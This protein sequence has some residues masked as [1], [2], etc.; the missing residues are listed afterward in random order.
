MRLNAQAHALRAE[1]R[2]LSDNLTEVQRDVGMSRAAQL[3]EAN[4]RLVLAALASQMAAEVATRNLVKVVS[5]NQRD[6]LTNTPNRTLMQDR[7]E[8]AMALAQRR[9]TR[10]AV[11]FVDLDNFKRINDTL[12]HAAGDA[13]LQTLARRL[14]SCV[15]ESDTVSRH[16]GDEFLVLLSEVSQASDAALIAKKLL[17]DIV[18]P[19][20]V[21]G[22]T[23]HTG[24]SLG[25]AI[26]PDDSGDADNLIKLADA[27]MDRS[28]RSG[29]GCY[30]FYGDKK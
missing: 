25:I 30:T 20:V 10:A 17:L 6:V 15:R 7:L 9:G 5:E 29:G 8:S 12:G 24:A 3:V 28:K 18:G 2:N 23:L 16:G 27:A 21:E 11:L 13:V 14:E 19:I 26:F 1:L 22:Q 4:E